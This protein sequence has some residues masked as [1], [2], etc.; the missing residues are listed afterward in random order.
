MRCSVWLLAALALPSVPASAQIATGGAASGVFGQP[1]LTS[2]E[3]PPLVSMIP[4]GVAADARR[5]LLYVSDPERNRVLRY[6]TRTALGTHGPASAVLGQPDFSSGMRATSQTGMNEPGA[7][8]V[9]ASGRLYVADGQ[10]YRVLRFDRPYDAPN[11]APADA[12]FG[13]EGFTQRVFGEGSTP[14]PFG[15][16]SGLATS[17]D[18]ALFV[19]DATNQRVLRFRSPGALPSG[20]APNLVLFDTNGYWPFHTAVD[21]SG[22]LFVS[23][24]TLPGSILHFDNAV[25]RTTGG[26][27]DGQFHLDDVGGL[28]AD[29]AGRLYA[30]Q[31]RPTQTHV[32]RFDVPR[33]ESPSGTPLILRGTSDGGPT[34]FR[35]PR[36][37]TLDGSRLWVADVPAVVGFDDVHR[38]RDS[39]RADAWIGSGSPARPDRVLPAGIAID[40]RTGAVFVADRSAN[41][42]LRFASL[43]ALAAGLPNGVLGQARFDLSAPRLSRVGMNSPNAIALD[44]TGTLFV[45]DRQNRR[46]LRFDAAITKPNGAPADGVLGQKDF[47][48]RVQLPT[49]RAQADLLSYPGGL[50]IGAAGALF[51]VDPFNNR[52]V[53]FDNAA[54]KPNGAPADGVLGQ[55]TLTSGDFQYPTSGAT[56]YGPADA[57]L[58]RDGRLFV[59]EGLGANRVLRFDN[60]ATKP[61]GA[62]ADGVL[63]QPNFSFRDY[64]ISRTQM[65]QPWGVAVDD[66]LRLYVADDLNARVLG[67]DLYDEGQM[68]PNGAPAA[69]VLGQQDFTS[70]EV[71][72]T[73]RRFNMPSWVAVTPNGQTL[74][75]SDRENARVLIF[76]ELTA[77]T[78]ESPTV[79][80][81]G[82]RVSVRGA[83]V[84][85]AM[86]IAETV[87][88]E[89]FDVLGRRVA[90]LH[91]GPGEA[92]TLDAPPSLAAGMYV[93]RARTATA[94]ATAPL[95]VH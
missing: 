8:A 27:F 59:S 75:M 81:S 93:V 84:H 73:A 53:R 38:R 66:R 22:H 86:P 39:V 60:A 3:A 6:D 30:T 1:T 58:S 68:A 62:P 67:F 28:A 23:A 90:V 69:L 37:L 88:V 15:G 52:V 33:S 54:T 92:L 45:S 91:D 11:G 89:V 85:V 12:V 83:R 35:S 4:G 44:D 5:G 76:G 36:A 47:E 61:D 34:G 63:G 57:T 70:R 14:L 55:P 21:S 56:L 95:R 82:L 46:V 13:Q 65:T 50:A 80:A 20:A 49:F 25:T 94:Q 74:L 43:A 71:G 19:V 24:R 16:I 7:L 87:R 29:A 18:D 10:N 26:A 42:V 64:G 72:T 17:G 9:D 51:V 32:L 40:R 78:A 79:P 77:T 41:R 2:R 31:A 48:T